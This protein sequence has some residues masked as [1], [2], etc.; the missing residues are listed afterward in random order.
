MAEEEIMIEDDAIAL[1]DTDD[2]QETDSSVSSIIGF[3]HE[4]YKR[5][6][7]YRYQDEE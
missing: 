1:D 7:D 6:E 2:S 5:A 3:I 4:R